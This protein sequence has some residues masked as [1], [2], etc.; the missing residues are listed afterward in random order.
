MFQGFK[1]VELVDNVTEEQLLRYYRSHALLFL[2]L[3]DGTAN[4]T[5]LEG[6]ACGVPI[7]TSD[8]GAVRDYLDDKSAIILR[9]KK[10]EVIVSTL[11]D[12]LNDER[13]RKELSVSARKQILSFDWEHIAKRMQRTYEAY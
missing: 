3:T 8:V 1:K 2:P 13:K 12:L 7:I 6:A 4:N 9:L 11:I 10:T 5:L